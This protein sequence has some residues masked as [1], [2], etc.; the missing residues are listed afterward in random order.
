MGHVGGAVGAIE[1]VEGLL[2]DKGMLVI[3][4]LEQKMRGL[5]NV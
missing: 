3:G 2:G 4:L 5:V 1:D